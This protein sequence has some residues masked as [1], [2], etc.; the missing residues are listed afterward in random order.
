VSRTGASSVKV[1]VVNEE[2][3]AKFLKGTDPLEQRVVVEQF[4]PG[5]TKRGPPIEWQI[6][7]VVHNVRYQGFRQDNPEVDVPFWQS[8]WSRAGIGVRTAEDPASMT[9]SIAA[10]VHAVD[11]E[12]ALA[13]PRTMDQIRDSM[14]ANDRFMVILF[15]SFAAIALLLASVGIYGVMAF[16]VAQ[17]SHEI[18][19]RAALGANKARVIGLVLRE[20]GALAGAG[21]VV[22]LVGAYLVGRLMRSVLFGVGAMDPAAFG[23]GGAHSPVC[24]A[25]RLLSTGCPR[26]I[27]RASGS[28]PSRIRPSTA[29]CDEGRAGDRE[30]R[31]GTPS[32]RC[33]NYR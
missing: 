15:A 5:V 2:F 19:V 21:L 6:V 25:T 20:G 30:C 16:S 22:G 11:P 1:A 31:K 17:R 24:R 4:I 33:K 10:A 18:A 8:P 13:A 7:G 28:P 27:S 26:C 12:I 32:A 14:L 29:S 3:V 9:K 23:F